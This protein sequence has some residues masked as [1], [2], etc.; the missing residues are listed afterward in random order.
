MLAS[1]PGNR[2]AYSCAPGK[3]VAVL[4]AFGAIGNFASAG[5]SFQDPVDV[6]LP[7]GSAPEALAV[8]YFKG[9]NVLDLAVVDGA[10]N[11]LTI[12]L[13]NTDGTFEQ[14]NTYGVGASPWYVTAADLNGD[15]IL[16][17]VVSNHDSADLNILL[18]VGDGSFVDAGNITISNNPFSTVVADFNSDGF[19]DIVVTTTVSTFL[20]LGNGDGTFGD[21]VELPFGPNARFVALGDFNGDGI[22]DLAVTKARGVDQVTI[23]TGN[24]DGSFEHVDDYPVG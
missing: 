21:P 9:D 2:R 20:I 11:S 23:E 22:P 18:G 16:D 10:G 8:G 12:L 14:G 4:L 3:V 19:A 7:D 13:G 17:L 15:N 6:P 5:I 24:G 1:S